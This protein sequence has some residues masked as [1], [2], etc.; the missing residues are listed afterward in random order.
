[1]AG[2][3]KLITYQKND[4]LLPSLNVNWIWKIYFNSWVGNFKLMAHITQISYV[5]N[6]TFKNVLEIAGLH[7]L[8]CILKFGDNLKKLCVF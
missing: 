6:H 7:G 3:V 2:D 4:V 8:T 5:L 1:M